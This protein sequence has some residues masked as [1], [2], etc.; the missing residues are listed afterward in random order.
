LAASVVRLGEVAPEHLVSLVNEV[1]ALA[2]RVESL[3]A[4]IRVL[5]AGLEVKGS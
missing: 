4:D 1:M 2:D 5:R 3:E